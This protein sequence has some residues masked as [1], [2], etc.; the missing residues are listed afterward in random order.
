MFSVQYSSP[1]ALALF[2]SPDLVQ[3]IIQINILNIFKAPKNS[4]EIKYVTGWT[5]C[6]VLQEQ[7]N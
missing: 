5:T 6:Q 4:N 1:T 2:V 3:R 7:T